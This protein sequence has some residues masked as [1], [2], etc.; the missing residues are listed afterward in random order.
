MSKQFGFVILHY[1]A[2]EMT[3]DCVEHI[4]KMASDIAVQIVIVDN[5]SLNNS[6]KLL[7]EKYKSNSN[8][9]VLLNNK[10]L[11]FAQGN[12]LGY[13]YLKANFDCDFIIVM[14]ND[15]LVEQTDFYEQIESVYQKTNF[16]VL[17]PDIFS[18][19][20]NASQSP[21]YRNDVKNLEG[22]TIDDI[23]TIYSNICK[24]NN[25]VSY[26]WIRHSLARIVRK[27]IPKK[28]MNSLK[29]DN[30]FFDAN[31]D[32]ENVVLHGACYIFSKDFIK[33]RTLC[34]NQNTFLYFEE[35]I[36]HYEC[37]KQKLKMIY[38]PAVKVIHLEDVSTDTVYTSSFKKT[39][40]INKNLEKSIK[41]F[42]DMAERNE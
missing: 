1:M 7:E 10:N 30:K 5:A 25:H 13:L 8:I 4:Q 33:Q 29:V 24:F 28:S 17:G 37:R 39:V 27:F 11:G 22:R 32:Y 26:Y 31:K 3:V 12:N 35:D 16:A 34:F 41:V 9:H 23:Q 14:N 20:L 36:L 38:S 42:L 2:Y 40:F 21:S 19:K 6:G 15:V 18:P